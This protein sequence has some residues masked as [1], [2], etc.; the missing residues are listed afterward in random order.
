[1]HWQTQQLV[2][3]SDISNEDEGPEFRDHKRS[4]TALG[5]AIGPLLAVFISCRLA[6]HSMFMVSAM[7]GI[8][9]AF[10]AVIVLR[11]KRKTESLTDSA[12]ADTIQLSD[13]EQEAVESAP[14]LVTLVRLERN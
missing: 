10:V 11:G 9:V 7:I 13:L 4:F 6:P 3:L 12:V 8:M 5:E 1:M 14:V 2:L